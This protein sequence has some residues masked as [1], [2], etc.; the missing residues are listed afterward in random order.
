VQE[1]QRATIRARERERL[2]A[3]HD[4]VVHRDIARGVVALDTP[5]TERAPRGTGSRGEWEEE[6]AE[7]HRRREAR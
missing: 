3:R 5:R 7:H 4:T 1:K 2:R 6:P